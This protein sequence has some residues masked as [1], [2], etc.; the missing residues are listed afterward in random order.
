[1]DDARQRL[2]G[3]IRNGLITC[4]DVEAVTERDC[5]VLFAKGD[6]T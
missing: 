2:G 1:M 5:D 3:I 4:M 6:P